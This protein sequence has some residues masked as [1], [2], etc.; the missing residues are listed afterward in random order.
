MD[1]GKMLPV[2]STMAER[3]NISILRRDQSRENH[4]HNE[5]ALAISPRSTSLSVYQ[6]EF[7]CPNHLIKTAFTNTVT[8]AIKFQHISW[9]GYPRTS[10]YCLKKILDLLSR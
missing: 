10:T 7:S 2:L 8:M 1:S 3:M 9:R 5:S 6:K 4:S